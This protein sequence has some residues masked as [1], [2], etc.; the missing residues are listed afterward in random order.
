MV[1]E[2]AIVLTVILK[3]YTESGIIFL[4]LTINAVIGYMQSR[5][6]QKAVELLKSRLKIK[7]KTLRDG[8]W[9]IIEAEEVVREIL[10]TL[11]AET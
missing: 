9:I 2:F 4:L 1:I 5:N 11:N 3:H 8:K 6:S 10:L 7:T